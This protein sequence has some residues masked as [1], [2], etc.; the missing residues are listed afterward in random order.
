MTSQV[1]F[2]AQRSSAEGTPP[3]RSSGTTAATGTPPR[4]SIVQTHDSIAN[5][6]ASQSEVL[7]LADANL[8]ASGAQEVTSR[9]AAEEV[10]LSPAQVPLDDGTPDPAALAASTSPSQKSS[11]S[12]SSRGIP[13]ASQTRAAE[14]SP[15]SPSSPATSRSPRSPKKLPFKPSSPC[16]RLITKHPPSGFDL[17]P[18]PAALASKTTPLEARLDFERKNARTSSITSPSQASHVPQG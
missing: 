16:P 13:S 18:A 5:G 11:L 14:R 9:D 2:E 8:E 12:Y 4:A 17:R 3:N 10:T 15:R 7:G 6:R 1:P